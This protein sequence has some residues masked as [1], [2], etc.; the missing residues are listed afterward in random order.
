MIVFLGDSI[1]EWWDTK[2]YE[3]YFSKFQPVNFGTAGYTSRDVIHFLE[4]TGLHGLK[5]EVI[6]LL[7]GTNNSDYGYTS[8]ET[9][10][11][12]TRILEI[13]SELSPESQIILLGILPRGHSSDR[14]RILNEQIN[15]K[16]KTCKNN[17]TYYADIGYLF[18]N[19]F[20]DISNEIMYD[21]L[22]LTSAGYKLLSESLSGLI[23]AIPPSSSKT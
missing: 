19:K 8:D 2:L 10:R 16:L 15:K 22:H 3:E 4:I 6:V 1:F 17:N 12:I 7:I 14:K 20:G 23:S 18:L 5:P 9:F 21:G 13:L 11:E